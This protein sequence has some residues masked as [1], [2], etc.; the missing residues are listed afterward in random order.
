MLSSF[1]R[2]LPFLTVLLLSPLFSTA[3]YTSKDVVVDLTTSNFKQVLSGEDAWLVE[4]YAPWCGHCKAL[5][6]EYRKAAKALEGV[7]KVGAVDMTKHES[8]GAQYGIK[9]F[10]TIKLFIGG[11][12]PKP[13]DYNGERTSSAMIEFVK[14]EIK[15]RGGKTDST[16]SASSSSSSSSKKEKSKSESGGKGAKAKVVELTESTFDDLVLQSDDLWLVEFFAPWCGHCKNLAPHWEK[17]AGELGGVARLGAVDAT[18]YQQLAGKYGVKGY[19]TIKV[20]KP[21]KKSAPDD[22]NGGRTSGDIVLYA[23]NLAETVVPAK[24]K[25]IHQLTSAAVWD[26]TCAADTCLVAVLPH[27]LDS[28]AKGRNAYLDTLRKVAA[29]HAK[30]PFTYLWTEMGQQS[31]VEEA[32]TGAFGGIAFPPALVAVNARKSRYAMMTGAFS[33]DG[34]GRF[35]SG[36]VSGAERTSALDKM[37]AVVDVPQWDGKDGQLP[38]ED[39]HDDL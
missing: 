35:I 10:P 15:A 18:V 36:I 24:P 23:K 6:P 22:Y 2:V 4:F 28:G 11:K 14:R 21:G 37:P 20:F 12:N 8:F 30:K 25:A 9:G 19:P 3:L 7:A 38:Q 5:V 1:F 16:A 31:A 33:E 34:I 32:L 27:I 39:A 13:I 17:A 26:E 29:T